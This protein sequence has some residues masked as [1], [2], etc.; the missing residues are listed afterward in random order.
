MI[1]REKYEEA[2]KIV[3]QYEREEY[4]YE[5]MMAEDDFDDWDEEE[6]RQAEEDYER[7][8]ACT[9]GAWTIG[10]DGRGYHVADCF[11]GAD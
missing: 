3:E 6:D 9:C 11:C 10:K 4:E 8:C 1:T 5:T 2:L 7:A